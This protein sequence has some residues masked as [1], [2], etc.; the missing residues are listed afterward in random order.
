VL[1][2][3]QE[4]KAL[5][6]FASG[7]RLNGTNN[8]AQLQAT[9]NAAVRAGVAFWPID[10]RG[11]VASAPMGDATQGSPG[12]VGMYTGA[13]ANAQ[14]G[15]L[16]R[17]QDTLWTLAADTGG[18]ALL[19]SND[20]GAGIVQAQKATE[21]YYILG[22]YSTNEKADGKFRKVKITLAGGREGTV[23]Y[24]QGYYGNKV[25]SKFST[26]DKERHLEDALRLGDPVTELPIAL[27]VGY[28]Q[29]NGA[30]YYVPVMVKIPGSELALARRG[31]AER[32]LIDFLGEVKDEYGTTVSNVRDKVELRLT[33]ATAAELARRPIEYDTGMTL[34][35]G[36][37][38]LKLL[39]RDAETGRMGTYERA[40]VVPNLAKETQ[41][42]PISSVVLSSQRMDMREA[43][44]NASKDKAQVVNPLVWEGKKIIPSVTRVFRA[45]KDLFVYFQAYGEEAVAAYVT[46]FSN[47]KKA[48]E[49]APVV[50][51]EGGT[52]RL[53]VR[54]VRFEIPLGTLLPGEYLCQVTVVEA[55]GAKAAFW[56]A[57][58]V[59]LP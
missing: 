28:F 58:L 11:L 17:S 36:N 18:K 13:T 14:R 57:H 4:K 40:F 26:A 52:N 6:Y 44:F 30:E 38:K 54:P 23:E 7:L 10:A 19:D 16:Q 15:I 46:F 33:G 27:E 37:Y 29:L 43:I 3:L 1:G 41:R 24:R 12:G 39:A 55:K 59:V 48:L 22:F 2:R 45:S 42:I 53:K 20:L 25:F 51:A 31:G 35:P 21:S 50:V 9:I 49:T 56:R 34:L 32:A 47:G 8:Q 5:V